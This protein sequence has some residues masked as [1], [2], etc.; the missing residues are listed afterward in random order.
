MSKH[1]AQKGINKML[2]QVKRTL[3]HKLLARVPAAIVPHRRSQGASE[4]AHGHVAPERIR[5]ITMDVTGTILR[6]NGHP[7]K[8]WVTPQDSSFLICSH[9]S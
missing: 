3:S 7:G 6:F 1:S 5:C 2:T 9:T 8:W 4:Q